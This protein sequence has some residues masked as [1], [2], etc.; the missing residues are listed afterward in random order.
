MGI[1]DDSDP[2]LRYLNFAR[3]VSKHSKY[4]IKVGCVIAKGNRPISVGFNKV[5]YNKLWANP[6]RKTLH[7]EVNAIRTSGKDYVKNT[8][9]YIYRETAKG[10]PAMARPCDDCMQKLINFGVKKI[11]Y[12]IPDYPYW[13]YEKIQ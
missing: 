5:K 12:S 2:H 1:D 4:K 10:I 9:A 6:W 13:S 3:N 8:T 11:Y 7:A